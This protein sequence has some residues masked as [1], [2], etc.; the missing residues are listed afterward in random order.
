M[1]DCLWQLVITGLSQVNPKSN[2]RRCRSRIRTCQ[3]AAGYRP[4]V[5]AAAA[6]IAV[7]DASTAGP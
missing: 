5:K 3:P 7:D 4:S 6:M 2:R 1:D